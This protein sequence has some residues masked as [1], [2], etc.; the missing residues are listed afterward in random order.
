MGIFCYDLVMQ[1]YTAIILASRDIGE[2]DRLYILYTL[3]QGLVKAVAK[4]VRKPAAKLAGHL[5]PGTLSEI[6]VAKA[7]GMGQ[8]TG[9][10]TLENF[11]NVK[12]DFGTL[13]EFLKISR[14]FLKNFSE[15]EKDKIIF[16]L[17][18]EFLVNLGNWANQ[19][20]QG[21]ILIEAFW[22]KL[23]DALGNRPEVIS[24]ASCGGKLSANSKKYFSIEKGSVVC[25]NCSS[26]IQNMRLISDNQIKLLRIF[27]GNPLRKIVKVKISEEEL[28]KLAMIREA[29]RKYSF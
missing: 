4:G 28:K 24:C 10:I 27:W 7:R 11:E 9:A 8:I 2:F 19:G 23:F 20:N 22:W 16:E 6:Y 13:S 17:L 1:K 26:N 3:E 14:F 25:A 21:K 18:R 12:K 15:G 29:F 5:E